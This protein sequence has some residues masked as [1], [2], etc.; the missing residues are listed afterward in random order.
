MTYPPQPVYVEPQDR[1]C[2]GGVIVSAVV[3][4]VLDALVAAVFALVFLR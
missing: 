4:F 3:A 2:H 1:D